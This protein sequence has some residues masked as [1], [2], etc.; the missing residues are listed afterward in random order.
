MIDQQALWALVAT[1]MDGLL[2]EPGDYATC[3]MT[4]DEDAGVVTFSFHTE[5]GDLVGEVALPLPE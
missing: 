4:P 5:A 3:G 1:A 2:I